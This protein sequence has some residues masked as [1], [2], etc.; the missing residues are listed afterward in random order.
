MG[1]VSAITPDRPRGVVDP[2]AG[3]RGQVTDGGETLTDG[4]GGVVTA[5]NL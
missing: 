1:T 3:W 2:A 4:D 5:T